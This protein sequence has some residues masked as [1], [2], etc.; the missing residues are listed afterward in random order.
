[1]FL[2]VLF[3]RTVKF[4]PTSEQIDADQ[5]RIM[6]PFINRYYGKAHELA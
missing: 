1:M 2:T 3:G 5:G 4:Y 6:T